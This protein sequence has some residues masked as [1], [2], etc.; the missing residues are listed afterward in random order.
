MPQYELNIRDYWLIIQKRRYIFLIIFIAAFILA[1]IYTNSQKPLYRASSSVQLIERKTL[2][3]LLTELVIQTMGDPLATQSRIITSLPVLERVVVE[4]GL[5]NGHATPEEVLQEA[6]DLRGKVLTSIIPDTS[7]IRII[8]NHRDPQMA[9][10]IANKIA[11][12]YVAE[13]L[14]DK[15]KESRSVREFIEQQL[16]EVGVKLKG[17]EEALAEFKAVEAPS[18]VALSFENKLVDLESKRQDLLK[19]YTPMHPDVKNTEEQISQLREQMKTLPQKELEYSRL[20]REAESDVKLYLELKG[21]LAGAR[22]NEAEK[23]EDVSVVDRAVP[24]DSP[25]SPNKTLNYLVGAIIGLVLGFTA[26]SVVEQLD[27]SIGTIEDVESFLKLPAL[28]VIPYLKTK[29]E[30]KKNLI[31]TLWPKEV[32]GKEKV[33]RLRNQLVVHYSSSSPIF[34]AYR[35]LRTNIQNEIFKKEA[36]KGKV[37]LFSSSG[38]EE[39]KSITISNLAIAMAQ[40]NLRTLLIDADMRRSVIHSI[41]G[42]KD[43]DPGLSNVLREGLE[44]EKAIKTFAD[45]L[46]GDLGFEETLKLPGLDNLNILTSGSLPSLPAELLSSPELEKLLENLKAKFDIILI[47]SPPVLA[48]ADAAILGSKVDGVILVYRVGKTARSVLLRSKT[49]LIDSGALVKGIIMN[50][51]SPEIEMRYGYY[52]HYKY[53]GKYYSE[54]KAET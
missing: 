13:N 2:G 25:I 27:T 35:I 21:K 44:P 40:G 16:Q 42:I 7:I 6:L 23:A 51:I 53:Y 18:G 37:L 9:A 54:K 10:N 20:K 24:P 8:V 22:I 32:E 12:V 34:E 43:R 17:S 30:K 31:Q 33:L 45:I 14:K 48:V 4:L 29:D 46:M 26:T 15:T 52:Y 49:Q 38:P 1:V 36:I 3:S 39:G 47:D 19:I 11:E 50:N 41:F 5:V 28:G